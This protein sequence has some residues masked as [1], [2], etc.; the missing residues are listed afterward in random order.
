MPFSAPKPCTYAGCSALV[1][2]GSGRCAKHPKPQFA[3]A[4]NA[5]KRITGRRLQAMRAALFSS[6][7]LC[8][9]C[10]AQGR[11]TLAT[12]RDH[13]VPLAEGGMDDDSNTQ[14]LCEA[15]HSIKSKAES[16]RG[17]ARSRA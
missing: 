17:V 12:Q 3:K 8:V 4:I 14:G 15:C 9:A 16:A 13:I 7:P 2:D 1:R 6:C 10:Q 5:T 11:I